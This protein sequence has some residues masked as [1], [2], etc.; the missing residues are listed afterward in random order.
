MALIDGEKT[1]IVKNSLTLI[2]LLQSDIQVVMPE[3]FETV[4]EY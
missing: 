4:M 2:Q 3:A 1:K